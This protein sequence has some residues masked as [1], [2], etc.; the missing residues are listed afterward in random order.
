MSMLD[1]PTD[2]HCRICGYCLY[3]LPRPVCPECG[4]GFDPAD[5]TTFS[6]G[7][8]PVG[9]RHLLVAII[10]IC[11]MFISPFFSQINRVPGQWTPG[12]IAYISLFCATYV[13]EL[14]VAFVSLG[15]LVR[16]RRQ[17]RR[18]GRLV[19]AIVVS[20]FVVIGCPGIPIFMAHIGRPL[21]D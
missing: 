15:D 1:L 17:N 4:T 19:A 3:G 13:T 21:V 5:S 8:K 2:A 7:I 12:M 9:G 18:T 14:I 10:A 20:L 16:L 6:R 11:V